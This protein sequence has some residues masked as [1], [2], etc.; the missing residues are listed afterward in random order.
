VTTTK[1]IAMGLWHLTLAARTRHT[2]FPDEAL[3]LEALRRLV[4]ICG[5]EL[6]VFCIVDDHLHWVVR[7]DERRRVVIARAVRRSMQAL[8]GVETKPVHA[9]PIDGRRHMETVRRYVLIQTVKHELGVHPALWTGGCFPDLVG[10][11]WL[12]E[13]RLQLFEVLPRSGPW[14]LCRDIGLPPQRFEPATLPQLRELGPSALVEAAAA[15]CGAPLSLRGKSR[16]VATARRVACWLGREA[17]IPSRK[18]AHALDIHPGAARKL[19]AKPPPREAVQATLVRIA[20][21]AQVAASSGA[22]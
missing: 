6:V 5:A 1:E 8:S 13:L 20:L 19:L 11:R 14:D 22:M 7:C 18:L 4:R 10:A 16:P 3:R 9:E 2:L 17:E 21:E 15:A 12:P